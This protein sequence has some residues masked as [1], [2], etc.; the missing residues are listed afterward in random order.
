MT[1]VKN[2]LIFHYAPALY[3]I[4]FGRYARREPLRPRWV[5]S[6]RPD[7]R[8]PPTEA[9]LDVTIFPISQ[10]SK[11]ATGCSRYVGRSLV[12]KTIRHVSMNL[13]SPLR[14]I[15]CQFTSRVMLAQGPF[16]VLFAHTGASNLSNPRD[17]PST[18]DWIWTADCESGRS[19]VCRESLT[20]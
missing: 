9:D 17:M 8:Y 5:R 12:L 18:A 4:G 7:E 19:G 3:V 2:P 20:P 11:H 10:S 16:S 14:S 13:S 1:G 6:I 15:P